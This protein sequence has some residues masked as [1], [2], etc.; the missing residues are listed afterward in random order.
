M[1]D[2]KTNSTITAA[3]EKHYH[4]RPPHA[5]DKEYEGWIK[6]QPCTHAALAW[7]GSGH[8]VVDLGCHKG[9]ISA[10]I[11]DNDNDVTGVDFESFT[12]IAHETYGLKV[13]PHDLNKP[14]PFEDGQF[15]VVVAISILDYIPGDLAFLKDCLRILEPGGMLIVGV[16]NAVSIYNRIA[17]L[18]GKAGRNFNDDDGYH[19]LNY[20]TAGGFIQL[21]EKAGFIIKDQRKCPKAYSKI[22]LRRI[23]ETI[24]PITFATDMAF[25]AVKPD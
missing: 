24:L 12:Q 15:D 19:T 22:P 17:T 13:K 7:I 6:D 18:M 11:R 2:T 8:R 3:I 23:V 5:T 1:S 10:V 4:A 25:K 20:Y 14:F 16:P 21:L 9:D